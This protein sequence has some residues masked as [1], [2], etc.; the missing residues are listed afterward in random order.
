MKHT[1]EI[2]K[3][4]KENPYIFVGENNTSYILLN[5]KT[6]EMLKTKID[7]E[8]SV[9]GF[10]IYKDL[11]IVYLGEI[12]E[13]NDISIKFNLYQDSK[14]HILDFQYKGMFYNFEDLKLIK[15]L[16]TE[17][18]CLKLKKIIGKIPYIVKHAPG[19]RE[20]NFYDTLALWTSS[21]RS[22]TYL[23]DDNGEVTLKDGR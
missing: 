19:V 23:I 9:N 5:K 7:E 20:G 11:G 10:T 6:G 1:T 22:G 2:S 13:I 18:L 16:T 14:K 21:V 3:L 4:K 15:E 8:K 17:E 12:L